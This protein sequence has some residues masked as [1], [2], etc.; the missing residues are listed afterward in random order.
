VQIGF[1]KSNEFSPA[2]WESY[3]ASFNK[4]FVKDFPGSYF[5][6]KYLATVDGFSFHSLLMHDGMVAGG[7]T[8]IP[9][10]Y[11]IREKKFRTALVVDV[12]I[13]PEF[14]NDP[15]T[16]YRMYSV[17]KKELIDDGIVFIFAVPNNTIYSYWKNIVKWK[18]V[19]MVRYYAFPLRIGNVIPNLPNFL[20]FV[21]KAL[22][23]SLIL[24]NRITR[25]EEKSSGIR[26]DRSDGIAE[27]QRYTS[28][29]HCISTP[30]AFFSFRIVSE[31]NIRTC[32]LIDYHNHHG[33]RDAMSLRRAL[34]HIRSSEN[35]D[36]ILFVGKIA[37]FQFL[38]F[39]I[40]FRYE[41]RHLPLMLDVLR[42]GDLEDP[43]FLLQSENW[44]FGLFNFDVR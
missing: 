8:A 20:S 42:P 4:T 12:F 21:S 15:Y 30:E 14:R 36:L 25:K 11:L 43:D 18:E 7:C 39:R 32:Y 41:P 34:G 16:L 13:L 9:F 1:K 22:F 24:L 17:L 35:V 38:L 29:H 33:K 26:I 3:C 2:E 10:N 37:F 28:D 27:R 5:R 19:G 44:D 23:T 6:H 40:P 31:Q